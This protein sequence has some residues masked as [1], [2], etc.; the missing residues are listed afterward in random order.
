MANPLSDLY[1]LVTQLRRPKRVHSPKQLRPKPGSSSH[2]F[3]LSDLW[4][5]GLLGC[6]GLCVPWKL[7]EAATCHCNMHCS[8]RLVHVI[9][10]KSS[11][12]SPESSLE[13]TE[14]HFLAGISL[15]HRD[16]LFF[17]GLHWKASRNIGFPLSSA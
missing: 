13:I 8:P 4:Y 12:R 3:G 5:I 9:T 11:R 16:M 7:V 1:H 6:H 2:D 10:G 17:L 15:F 14:A